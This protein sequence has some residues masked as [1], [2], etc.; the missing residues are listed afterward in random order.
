M[1]SIFLQGPHQEA[2]NLSI[3]TSQGLF[4]KKDLKLSLF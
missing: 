2:V 1:G 3:V 4:F